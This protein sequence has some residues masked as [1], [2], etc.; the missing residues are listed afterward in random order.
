V[1]RERRVG[2]VRGLGGTDAGNFIDDG[3]IGV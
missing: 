1:R 2:E 3:G